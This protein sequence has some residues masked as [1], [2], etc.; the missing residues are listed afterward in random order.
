M[1]FL[2]DLF[3]D[4]SNINSELNKNFK[5]NEVLINNT[6]LCMTHCVDENDLVAVKL[7]KTNIVMDLLYLTRDMNKKEAQKTC[8]ILLAKLAKKDEK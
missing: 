5:E 3:K 1:E 8:A 6:I 2:Y 7:T 4:C